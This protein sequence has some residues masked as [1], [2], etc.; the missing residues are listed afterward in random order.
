MRKVRSTNGNFDTTRHLSTNH[1]VTF[2]AADSAT[3][4]SYMQAQHWF[5][6]ERLQ[7]LGYA[8]ELV[9]SDR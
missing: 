8:A 1:V 6:V 9:P 3:C 5:G 7:R 4:V 2:A